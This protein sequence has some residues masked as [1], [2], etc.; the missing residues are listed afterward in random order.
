MY[1]V[2]AAEMR[3]MDHRTIT[4]FGLPGRLLMENAGRGATD[5]FLTVFDRWDRLRVGVIAGKGNN[6]GDGFVMARYLSIKGIKVTVFLLAAQRDVKGDAQANLALLD[7][8]GIPVI[9]IPDKK[10]FIDER[11]HLLQ[12]N[13]YIDAILGT[14]LKSEVQGFF[15]EVIS[16]IKPNKSPCFL[17]GHPI[18][19]QFRYR[20][21]MR[22]FN[23]GTSHRHLC[24]SENRPCHSPG[25]RLYREAE[26]RGYR[27]S[28]RDHQGCD[29]KS[30][31][32]YPRDR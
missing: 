10:T 24:L 13:I 8:L 23:S 12:H 6:G 25:C 26:S 21:A 27:H 28:G 16:F 19:D 2:T 29:T 1:L 18:G 11:D 3:E 20:P 14:G 5:F 32:G 7:K 9:E 22:H 4:E 17:R 30:T 15:K 31:I